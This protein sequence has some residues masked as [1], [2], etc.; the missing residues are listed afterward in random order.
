[1]NEG[2]RLGGGL[3]QNDLN[4]EESV[5]AI[6]QRLV[7]PIDTIAEMM[8][9]GD[10]DQARHAELTR[11]LLTSL[12]E[13][14]REIGQGRLD[15]TVD[16]DQVAAELDQI[17]YSLRDLLSGEATA[18]TDRR[19]NQGAMNVFADGQATAIFISQNQLTYGC[20]HEPT[21]RAFNDK[22]N[23]GIVTEAAG[24][25]KEIRVRELIQA[26][27]AGIEDRGDR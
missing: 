2:K 26:L 20:N 16:I 27:Y 24:N 21:V 17:I 25:Q 4:P 11:T 5:F 19:S 10:I 14:G 18:L 6:V 15:V 9:H 7:Q 8:L 3:R 22:V 12:V 13:L 1:M 23:L